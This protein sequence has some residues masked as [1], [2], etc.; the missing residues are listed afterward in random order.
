[1][2][3]FVGGESGVCGGV[4]FGWSGQSSPIHPYPIGQLWIPPGPRPARPPA[5]PCPTL[6]VPVTDAGTQRAKP[7]GITGC[8]EPHWTQDPSGPRL[9]PPEGPPGGGVRPPQGMRN[10]FTF[11]GQNTHPR[12]TPSSP[13][14]HPSPPPVHPHPPTTHTWLIEVPTG[15]SRVSMGCLAVGL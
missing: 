9:E 7:L 6:C 5:A 15:C 11:L 14:F 13:S 10:P 12:S 3:P 1:M 4:T 8:P 2:I